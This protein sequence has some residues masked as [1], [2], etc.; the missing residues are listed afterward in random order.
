MA[1]LGPGNPGWDN[2][3]PTLQAIAMRI[4]AESG[5]RVWVG[6]GWRSIEQQ[7]DLYNRWIA[8]TYDVPS[9]AKPGRSK[10]NHGNAIDFSGDLRLAQQLGRKYGLIFP[11]KG[12]AWH[13]ELSGAAHEHHGGEQGDQTQYDINYT[14][15]QPANPEDVLANRMHTIMRLI[16]GNDQSMV[17]EPDLMDGMGGV[18]DPDQFMQAGGTPWD[19]ASA[20]FP[21]M[22]GMR[23]TDKTMEKADRNPVY[24]LGFDKKAEK[25]QYQVADSGSFG[26][27]AKSLFKQFGF[28]EADYPALVHLWNK[29]SGSPG[30][31]SSKVTWNPMAQNPTSTAYGIAQFLNGT[32]GGTGIQKTSNPQQQIMAGLIYIRNR[33][34]NPR[35]ALNFHLRNNWY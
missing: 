12:E 19:L 35:N 13:G 17:M 34:G 18:T 22:E 20:A 8:G 29:E 31:G 2:L 32:W 1:G 5:G 16:G 25:A 27:Y 21:M 10:H 23:Q 9:V 7:T 3:N 15:G 28:E 24:T 30:A 6:S 26:A 11:V 33:Y 4:M 14:G